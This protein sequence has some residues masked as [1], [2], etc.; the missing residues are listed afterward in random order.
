MTLSAPGPETAKAASLRNRLGERH[1]IQREMDG[2][3]WLLLDEDLY[4]TRHGDG[5]FPH[6]VK[7]FADRSAAEA[8]A[9]TKKV[10]NF[11]CAKHPD[12]GPCFE[13][14]TSRDRS[15]IAYHIIPARVDGDRVIWAHYFETTS[16][17]PKDPRNIHQRILE[18]L[19]R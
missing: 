5:Y 1:T 4:E 6:F 8:F 10:K 18:T 16:P 11:K 9:R 14:V 13:E 2:P 15:G 7:A 17:V 3:I 19:E 12:A